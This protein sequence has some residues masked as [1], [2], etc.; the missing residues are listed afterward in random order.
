MVR[1]F[2]SLEVVEASQGVRERSIALL[3]SADEDQA[4]TTVPTCPQWTAKE[5]ACHMYGVCDDLL[6]GR[7]EGIGSD[8]WTQAQVDRH[9]SKSLDELVDE[10]AGSA[11]T[12]DGIVPHFPE[13]SN[14][15]LVMDQTTHEHDLRLALGSPGGQDE[16]SSAIGAEFM[17]IAIRS[18]DP[19]LAEQIEGLGVSE[20]E[21]LRALT[22]RRSVA[23][24]E[25]AGIPA[26]GID[27]ILGP[28]PMT[29][30]AFDV[31][32]ATLDSA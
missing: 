9:G 19:G 22:G 5:L 13:P 12:F 1:T 23:Q 7:L 27:R 15:Q 18:S 31:L 28:S 21:L 26:E 30:V 20:F 3:R 17:L 24:L 2:S 25:A 14:Y 16:L 10:W 8:T 4:A 32:E 11:A 29:I 6:C